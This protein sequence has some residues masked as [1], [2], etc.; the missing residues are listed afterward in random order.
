M[1]IL[2][3]LGV[4]DRSDSVLFTVKDKAI[5]DKAADED[6]TVDKLGIANN[7]GS[8]NLVYA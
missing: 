2:R 1:N 5:V 4:D 7:L 3:R 6:F 8:L